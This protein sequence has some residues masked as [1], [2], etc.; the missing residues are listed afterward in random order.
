PPPRH[1]KGNFTENNNN[2]YNTTAAT[3][4]STKANP[5][6]NKKPTT[7]TTRRQDS[8]PISPM[9]NKEQET[10]GNNLFLNETSFYLKTES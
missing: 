8:E 2:N 9:P 7:T 4:T 6:S 3:T 10:S 5:P 1:A